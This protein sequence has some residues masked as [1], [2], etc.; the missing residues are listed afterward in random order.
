MTA[1]THRA[2]AVWFISIINLVMWY[3]GKREVNFYLGWIVMLYAARSGALFPDIDHQWELVKEKTTINHILNVLIHITGGKHRSWQTHSWDIAIV[4]T[5]VSGIL[6]GYLNERGILDG[7]NATI[8]SLL[9]VGFA[10]GWVSHLISDMLTSAGVRVVCWRGNK[11]A[12]VPKKILGF[13]FNTGHE[14]EAMVY[15]VTK[16][17]NVV[18]GVIGIIAPILIAVKE[19]SG[20]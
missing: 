9:M 3:T 1:I 11:I 16:G 12:L 14:W 19:V 20:I 5:V 15:K 10:V 2:F 13:R 4:Y 8:L 7:T 6:P 17:L 18:V